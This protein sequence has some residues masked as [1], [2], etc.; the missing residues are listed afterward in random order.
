MK[1]ILHIGMHKTGSTSIQDTFYLHKKI[2]NV[3]YL[4]WSEANHSPWFIQQF[5]HEEEVE[6]YHSFK[7]RGLN[8][9]LL[10]SRREKEFISIGKFLHE[11]R[12][13][14]LLISA[15]DVSAP[16]FQRAVE[17]LR[18]YCYSIATAVEVIGYVRPPVSF[19]HSVFQ[20]LLQNAIQADLA[21]RSIP[22]RYRQRFETILDCF[23]KENVR[24]RKFDRKYLYKQDVVL[25][26]GH[27][28]GLNM[29]EDK[30]VRSNESL[31]L[32]AI[33]MLYIQ[34]KYGEGFPG[35]Y[36]R[37]QRDNNA[38]IST[39]NKVGNRKLVFSSE[40][41]GPFLEANRQDIRWME[42]VLG[43]SLAEKLPEDV[44]AVREEDDFCRIAYDSLKY[45]GDI[46]GHPLVVQD[47]R[48]ESMAAALDI[49]R[50]SVK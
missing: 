45:I 26:F 32:E 14:V 25:D 47:R 33:S 28:I 35:G 10:L 20:Q 16:L 48:P 8:R 38:F 17:P 9:D 49:V 11:S 3:V 21:L 36:D 18:D 23:G 4:P 42:D 2:G 12:P 29:E 31:T 6:N 1:I 7:A 22:T 5:D 19:L 44:A 50:R 40:L 37:A 41:V 13:Q 30:V 27:E 46:V 24:L 39:L 43:E 15:E 34:R